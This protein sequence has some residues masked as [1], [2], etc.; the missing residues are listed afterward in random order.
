M[1]AASKLMDRLISP[2][3][4]LS[5]TAP[6][7][8]LRRSGWDDADLDVDLTGRVCV[9]TGANAGLGRAA[10]GQLADL[11]ATVVLVGRSLDRL[12]VARDELE[13]ATGSTALTT[14]R[15]DVG[16]LAQVA[17]LAGRLEDHFGRLD[18][19]VH[20]A[21]VLLDSRQTTSDGNE[22][23]FAIN[24]LGPFRLT[25]ELQPLLERSAPARVVHV[26]SGGMYTQRLDLNTLI[27]PPEPFDGV[28]AYAQTKRAQVT[29]SEL[30]AEKLAGTGVTSN[31]MHPG[32]ADTPG[33]RSSLPRFHKLT[34][35]VLRNTR[36]GAD[37]IVWL[38]ASPAAASLN[39]AFVFDRRPRSPYLLPGT[40]ETEAER[41]K[42]WQLCH[43]RAQLTA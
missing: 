20:N 43:E 5:F 26:S 40:R 39:G 31:A 32:W 24:L 13:Q 15:C 14:E 10:A 19:L 25:A 17:A 16:E 6:G 28:R 2:L 1:C 38:A 7:Y 11:G 35:S 27:D 3:V 41:R 9:V 12:K 36:Q 21:G 29:L 18:V 42:L 4:P 8:R 33:V 34:R 30:W 37:S 23:T 22:A